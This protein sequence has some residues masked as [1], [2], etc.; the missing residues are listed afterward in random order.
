[1]N[2]DLTFQKN[3]LENGRAPKQ[4]RTLHLANLLRDGKRIGYLKVTLIYKKDADQYWSNLWRF[5]NTE[6]GYCIFD[7]KFSVNEIYET[8]SNHY[9][10]KKDLSSYQERENEINKWLIR[11][12]IDF[13][14]N[15]LIEFWQDKPLADF[16]RVSDSISSE[17]EKI[18]VGTALYEFAAKRMAEENMCLYSL[19]Y[20]SELELKCWETMGKYGLPIKY[21]CNSF[22][23]RKFIDYRK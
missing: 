13:H 10:C 23:Q 7:D 21:E 18:N 16:L 15:R 20:L 3:I 12:R 2:Y 14:Y 8:L 4:P 9:F 17:E 6:L 1:M 5:A 22:Y 11:N 19:V